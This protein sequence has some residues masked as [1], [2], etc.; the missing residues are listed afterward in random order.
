MAFERIINVPN[1]GLGA[2]TVRTLQEF[3]R[4]TSVSLHESA[5]RLLETDE[6]RPQA[7]AALRRLM[8]DFD[9]WRKDLELMGHSDL[10]AQI[11]E[12]SG[13]VDMWQQSKDVGAEGRLENLKELVDGVA[14]FE[15]LPGFL[16]HISLVMDHDERSDQPQVSLMT[17]HAAKGLEFD[18]VFLPGWEEEIF[19]TGRALQEGG[20]AALEEERRLAYVGLTRARKRVWISWATTRFFHGNRMVSRPSRFIDEIA[21]EYL[22]HVTDQ[23]PGNRLFGQGSDPLRGG[24]FRASPETPSGKTAPSGSDDSRVRGQGWHTDIPPEIRIW[25]SALQ[26]GQ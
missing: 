3:A 23:L 14:Q 6:L 4:A 19:P 1:R 5:L 25:R 9:R 10:V 17:L 8:A 26:R 11:L 16:E 22:L 21:S 18:N 7:R 24:R 2:V 20:N 15:S 13:Y 12:E